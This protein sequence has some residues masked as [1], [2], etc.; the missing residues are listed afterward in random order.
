VRAVAALDRGDRSHRARF[1]VGNDLE[2]DIAGEAHTRLPKRLERE[3]RRGDAAFHVDGAA[4]VETTVA[5]VAGERVGGPAFP[6]P[7]TDD[8]DVAVDEERPPPA[9]SMEYP[10]RERRLCQGHPGFPRQ[11]R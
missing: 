5:N 4:T 7:W 6:L 8:V 1:L 3:E 2:D 10:D 9:G 11:A